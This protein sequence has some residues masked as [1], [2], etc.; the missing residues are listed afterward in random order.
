MKNSLIISLT[1]ILFFSVNYANT[2]DAFDSNEPKE[3]LEM[4]QQEKDKLLAC[5]EIISTKLRKDARI[6]EEVT[7]ILAN[8]VNNDLVSQKVTG[9]LLNKCYYSIDDYTVSTIFQNGVY[10]EPEID[11]NLLEFAA[12]DYS[13]YKLLS[14]G[15]FSITPETQ[16]LYMKIEKARN[17][18]LVTNKKRQESSRNDFR[19]FGYSLK[20]IPVSLNLI[21]TIVILAVVMG[22]LLYALKRVMKNDK[23]AAG[24]K[25]AK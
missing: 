17:D 3:L 13:T 5:T 21:L 8:K 25:K 23:K 20:E 16:M 18:F 19:I 1:F 6:I 14:P 11:D 22:S 24:R 10:M 4:D 7:S 2:Q 9:D 12:V 15:E